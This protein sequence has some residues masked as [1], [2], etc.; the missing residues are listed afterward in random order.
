MNNKI[1]IIVI[2]FFQFLFISKIFS[3]EIQFNANEI[4]VL[5]GGNE[6]I[7]KMVQ[8]LFKMIRFL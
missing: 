5:D 3:K 7:A 6:T 4:E 8:H 1:F 2:I